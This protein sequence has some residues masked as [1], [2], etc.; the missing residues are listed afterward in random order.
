MWV[1][2][3]VSGGQVRPILKGGGPATRNFLGPTVNAQTVWPRATKFSR[4]V[5]DGR[6]SSGQPRPYPQGAGYR[7]AKHLGPSTCA[8]MVW[9]TVTQFCIVIQLCYGRDF[10]KST[11]EQK[12]FDSYADA[13]SVCSSIVIVI[14]NSIN[15]RQTLNAVI[16]DFLL[17]C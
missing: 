10:C 3:R 5:E 13:R 11:T 1:K 17:K 15:C 4:Q 9:E 8:H 7:R 12:M 14:V 2:R 16:K 6:V